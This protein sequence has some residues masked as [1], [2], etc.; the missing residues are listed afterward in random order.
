M[1]LLYSTHQPL[2]LFY[3][4]TVSNLKTKS[5]YL[6]DEHFHWIPLEH[7]GNEMC[8]AKN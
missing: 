6:E 3:G 4:K 7:M 8:W 5:C 2:W 1:F